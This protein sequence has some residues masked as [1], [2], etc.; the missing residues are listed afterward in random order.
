MVPLNRKMSLNFDIDHYI[1][2]CVI[3]WNKLLYYCNT[4]RDVS[5][6]SPIDILQ[7]CCVHAE[8][9]FLLFFSL[10]VQKLRTC[11]IVNKYRHK[12]TF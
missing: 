2:C 11:G 12:L 3:D 10:V 5:Y 9:V 7:L 1:Y 8:I 6:P 4:Q